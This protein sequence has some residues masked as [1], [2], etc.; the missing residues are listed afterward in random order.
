MDSEIIHYLILVSKLRDIVQYIDKHFDEND[1][2]TYILEC[3]NL[4]IEKLKKESLITIL[5]E[6]L[7]VQKHEE[8]TQTEHI[9]QTNQINVQSKENS[10]DVSNTISSITNLLGGPQEFSVKDFDPSSFDNLGSGLVRLL[11]INPQPTPTLS[12][13]QSTMNLIKNEIKNTNN[14][15]NLTYQIKKKI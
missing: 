12:I 1:I 6:E 13:Q 7:S 10:N 11:K 15:N 5:I 4:C 9:Q 2:K 8:T 14:S 3:K